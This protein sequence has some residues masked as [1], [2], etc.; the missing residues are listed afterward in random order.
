MSSLLET[1]R[2]PAEL[3]IAL[4]AVFDFPR[5]HLVWDVGHQCYP[6]K[7]LTGQASRFHT[8]RSEGEELADP[9]LATVTS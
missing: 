6:H 2:R 4:H 5:D 1:L 7:L 8:L 3:A 9:C